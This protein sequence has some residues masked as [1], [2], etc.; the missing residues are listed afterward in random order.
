M[1]LNSTFNSSKRASNASAILNLLKTQQLSTK[2][3]D[4]IEANNYIALE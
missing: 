4:Q 2:T 3:I 1:I